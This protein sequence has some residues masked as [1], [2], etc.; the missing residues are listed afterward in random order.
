MQGDYNIATDQHG[1]YAINYKGAVLK[2][3]MG[4]IGVKGLGFAIAE[5]ARK[6]LYPAVFEGSIMYVENCQDVEKLGL[7][8]CLDSLDPVEELLGKIGFGSFYPLRSTR[9]K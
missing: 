6:P 4:R 8:G 1:S 7:Y 9:D 3:V 2:L 5:G